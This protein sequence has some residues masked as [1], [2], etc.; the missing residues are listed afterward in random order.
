MGRYETTMS[1]VFISIPS[2]IT[3]HTAE[4]TFLCVKQT[5]FGFA[6]APDVYIIQ[7][8]ASGSGRTGS[9]GFSFPYKI[10]D[11]TK[12]TNFNTSSNVNNEIPNFFAV[13]STSVENVSLSIWI[14]VCKVG[15][16]GAICNN[17]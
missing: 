6:S 16:F 12:F 8:K 14:I 13:S 4:I 2:M 1:F 9:T 17:Y 7:A 11:I 3:E 5:P 15:H 10:I